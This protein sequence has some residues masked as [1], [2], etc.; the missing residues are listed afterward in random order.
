MFDD[1]DDDS[2]GEDVVVGGEDVVVGGCVIGLVADEDSSRGDEAV[3]L[4][5]V[6]PA[7][8]SPPL[9]ALPLFQ[10]LFT[11]LILEHSARFESIGCTHTLCSFENTVPGPHVNS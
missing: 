4:P 9:P 7:P 8:D 10:S 2:G 3:V 6:V 5:C 1:G 11:S